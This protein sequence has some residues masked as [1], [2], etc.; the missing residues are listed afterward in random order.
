VTVHSA[1]QFTGEVCSL[2]G[3]PSLTRGRAREA[4]ELLVLDGNALREV[5]QNDP[6]LSDVLMRAFIL[7]R[8][9]LLSSGFGDATLVGSKHSAG[10]SSA[11]ASSTK[12]MRARA[13][14]A[15]PE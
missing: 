1:G 6:D 15:C 11:A 4:G 13:L 9:M 2:S 10:R 7:R 3:R 8:V 14:P 5:I 12:R